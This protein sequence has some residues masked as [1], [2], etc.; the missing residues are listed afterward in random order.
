MKRS[1][2]LLAGLI[3]IVLLGALAI[4]LL[5]RNAN[6]SG[7]APEATSGQLIR[8]RAADDGLLPESLGRD[9]AGLPDIAQVQP[10]IF[11]STDPNPILGV[12]PGQPIRIDTSSGATRPALI[13]GRDLETGDTGSWVAL[14]GASVTAEDYEAPGGMTGMVHQLQPGQSILLDETWRIRIVGTVT[15]GSDEADRVL[16]LPLDRVQEIQAETGLVSGFWLLLE[17]GADT[18]SLKASI[19]EMIP[20]AEVA[21]V[22]VNDA[23]TDED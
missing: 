4:A 1:I 10:F 2:T 7:Q 3:A 13:E 23:D 20:D 12:P 17:P 11:V 9:L 5:F 19:T 6:P 15:T 22:Q 8:V 21:V 18:Q 16:I 14:A